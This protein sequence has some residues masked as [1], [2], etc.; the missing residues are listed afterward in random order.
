M[1]IELSTAGIKVGYCIETVAGTRP[2][3][4][5]NQIR[6]V[7][8]IPDFNPEPAQL[9][10]TDLSDT[11]FKRYIPGLKDPSGAQGLTVNEFQDFK[12]DWDGMMTAYGSAVSSNLGMWVQYNIPNHDAYFFRA[13]PSELGFNGADVD[14]V[15][16]NV[17]YLTPNSAPVWATGTS[18]VHA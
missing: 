3:T 5:Y 1:A 14:S 8:S 2:T 17:A 12:D 11:E 9:E 18:V 13:V 7:K 16:E 6:G 10:V 4:S 15:L